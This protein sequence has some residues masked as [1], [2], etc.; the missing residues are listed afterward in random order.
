MHY[1]S[2]DLFV[3]NDLRMRVNVCIN[4]TTQNMQ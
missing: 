4:V 1:Y 2:I 3:K